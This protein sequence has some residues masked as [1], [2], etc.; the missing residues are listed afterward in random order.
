M[1]HSYI[2]LLFKLHTTA[3]L[4]VQCTEEEIFLGVC[5]DGCF[6]LSVPIV[7]Y[8]LC[9][10]S[11]LKPT[12]V[13]YFMLILLCH[14]LSC[15]RANG[16]IAQI[17]QHV[18]VPTGIP[19]PISPPYS[20]VFPPGLHVVCLLWSLQNKYETFELGNQAMYQF[21]K[22]LFISIKSLPILP[23]TRKSFSD[24]NVPTLG[25]IH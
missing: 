16:S 13:R 14:W 7:K 24:G 17:H 22:Y 25:L 21:L 4:W 8:N 10:L 15:E 2:I 18:S 19:L 9:Q 5:P 3:S 20:P 23:Q 11:F 6:D 12:L 1:S